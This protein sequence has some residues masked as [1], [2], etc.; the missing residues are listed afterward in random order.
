MR[1]DLFELALHARR[2]SLNLCMTT[3][4][5]TLPA[6]G[7]EALGLFNQVNV[8][9]HG[10]EQV[11]WRA[12]WH[13]D[14]HKIPRRINFVAVCE[15]MARLPIIAV[16]AEAFDTE[17]LLLTAKGGAGAPAPRAVMAEARKLREQGLCLA[18][19]GL[20]CAGEMAEFCMPS[21]ARGSLPLIIASSCGRT[22]SLRCPSS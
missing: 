13:L 17:L 4:G 15:H 16:L 19:D 10:D 11:L 7:P 3:T 14:D 6:L 8:S 21:R 5:L 20:T 2:G 12:L 9:C 22:S 1:A 18:V